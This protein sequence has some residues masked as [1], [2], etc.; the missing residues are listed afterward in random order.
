MSRLT[1]LGVR[2]KGLVDCTA[3]LPPPVEK[4]SGA[5]TP[6]PK[7]GDGGNG[8]RNGGGKGG[9]R[10]GGRG[11]RDR[12][13]GQQSETLPQNGTPAPAAV[14]PPPANPGTGIIAKAPAA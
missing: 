9:G 4:F 2:K 10:G 7:K 6:E 12:G 14:S 11:G 5:N 13:D 3:A 1:L 8:G